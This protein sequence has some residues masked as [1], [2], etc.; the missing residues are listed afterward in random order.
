M[1]RIITGSAKGIP[2]ATLPGEATR[3]TAERTK[4]AVFSMIGFDIEGREVLDLFSGSGQLALEALSRGAGRAVLV[5]RSREAIAIIRAN[6]K[7]TRLEGGCEIICSD[8]AGFISRS[9]GRKF[10]IVFLDPPYASELCLSS[11]CGLLDADMLKP[12]S[13]IVCETGEEDLFK[14][15]RTIESRFEVIKK[16]K[17]G[18]AYITILTPAKE[19]YYE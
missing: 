12:S 2:L 6:A 14:G 4:E 15:N 3:P 8:H 17:Y 13:I 18:R 10:D 1:M 9:K 7:K 19:E 5:D 16:A 11:L